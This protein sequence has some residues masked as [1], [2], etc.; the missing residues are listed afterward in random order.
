MKWFF[1]IWRRKISRN[2]L[3]AIDWSR[4]RKASGSGTPGVSGSPADIVS[5][6]PAQNYGNLIPLAVSIDSV[7]DLATGESLTI[8]LMAYTE[9]GT[10]VELMRKT[11]VTSPSKYGPADID[12]SVIPDKKRI[13]LLKVKIESSA[14]STTASVTASVEAFES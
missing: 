1:S 12:Y 11:G 5:L 6:S 3:A 4:Y 13:V 9:D 7:S 2:Q 14:T 10:G 8:I